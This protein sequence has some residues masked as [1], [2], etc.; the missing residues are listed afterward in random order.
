MFETLPNLSRC[1][2]P[3]RKTAQTTEA[4]VF[5]GFGWG[6]TKRI[7]S[8]GLNRFKAHVQRVSVS[9][10]LFLSPCLILQP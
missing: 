3:P 7:E 6:L 4:R 8:H 10:L 9:T 2:L 5:S 1:S